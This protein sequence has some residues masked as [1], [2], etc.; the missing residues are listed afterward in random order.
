MKY[1][2][3]TAHVINVKN[4]WVV[5]IVFLENFPETRLRKCNFILYNYL[6]G[7]EHISRYHHCSPGIVPPVSPSCKGI[8]QRGGLLERW[9]LARELKCDY[10]EIPSDF[11]KNKTEIECTG[12]RLGE[13]L[14]K[15]DITILYER[16][17]NLSPEIKYI[18]HTE[19]SLPRND[20][21]GISHQAPLEWHSNE[22]VQR[23]TDMIISL[24]QF[25]GLPASAIEIH[26][27]DKRNSFQNVMTSIESLLSKY[28]SKM[29]SEPL[30]LLENRTGQFI[31]NGK[32][33][34]L[35]WDY[36]IKEYPHIKNKMGVVLD[37]QQ[38]YTSTK[39]HF[40]EEL[41]EIPLE[42][43]KGFHI[44]T[45]HRK[46]K[47]SDEIPWKKVFEIISKINH[48][49]IIN[50]EIHHKNRIK[51]TIQFCKNML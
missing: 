38:L 16:D 6:P 15:E 24:S 3:G 28:K 40:L 29:D 48:D 19:P 42:S 41:K 31:S 35:F 5:Y 30:I 26:P 23:L 12:K 18:L 17:S 14:T 20:G 36:L 21:Y 2:L 45:K 33:I 34:K 32:E 11:I 43:I 49:V 7:T 4:K 8:H 22:W 46:P 9:K 39:K 13:F 44:H 10:I 47:L 25:F 50:P 37:I 51:D 27:G 1:L